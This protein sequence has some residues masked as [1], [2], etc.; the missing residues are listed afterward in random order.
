MPV[1]EPPE[2]VASAPARERFGFAGGT[3][4]RP[5][6]NLPGSCLSNIAARLSS[7]RTTKEM[8]VTRIN[9]LLLTIGCALAVGF[10]TPALALNPQPLPPGFRLNPQPLPPGFKAFATGG[11]QSSVQMRKAGGSQFRR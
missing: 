3:A 6:M 11:G 9:Y 2:E 10:G 5:A 4:I 7:P 8:T 1:Q